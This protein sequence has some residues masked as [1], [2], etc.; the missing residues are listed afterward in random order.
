MKLYNIKYTLALLVIM[1]CVKVQGQQDPSF[2]MYNLNMNIINPAYA[3]ANDGL[4]LTTLIRGQW[5]GIKDA[6]STQTLSLSYPIGKNV[7]LGLSIVNDQVF[8]TKETD[9]YVDFSYK[10]KLS[11]SNTLFLGL[12]AGATF[13]NTD[14]NSLNINDPLFNQNVNRTNPNFGAGAYLKG[15]NYYASLS[16]PVLLQSKRY[17]KEGNVV[18]SAS[19]KPHIYLGAGYTFDLQGEYKLK[20]TPSFMTRYVSGVPLSADLTA[21]VS[22]LDKVEFG[23]SH[24]LKESFS[25][26]L[27]FQFIKEFKL[28]YAYEHATNDISTYSSGSHEFV[29]KFSF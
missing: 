26:L 27:M 20:L 28:G 12:K 19:D 7:G 14:L 5:V 13:F 18:T 25:G 21:T 16:V 17:E 2:T 3:G 6:P 1:V 9:V 15:K 24:R 22:L 4:E 10:L 29:F 23:V 8:V 11:E